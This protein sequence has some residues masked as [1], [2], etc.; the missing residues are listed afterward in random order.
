VAGVTEVAR[1]SGVPVAV[2]AGSST[3]SPERATG[4]G[5]G[6]LEVSAPAETPFEEIVNRAEGLL[7]EAARRFAVTQLTR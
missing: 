7:A 2:I 5:L 6:A 4:L 1:R 3:I